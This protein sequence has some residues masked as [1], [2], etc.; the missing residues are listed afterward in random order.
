MLRILLQRATK[1]IA[2]NK[3][4]LNTIEGIQKNTILSEFNNLKYRD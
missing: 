4:K 2:L 1:E 3:I